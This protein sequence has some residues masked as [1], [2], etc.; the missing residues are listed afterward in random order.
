M[1]NKIFTVMAVLG[2][3]V[4]AGVANAAEVKGMHARIIS[5]SDVV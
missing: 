2:L 5:P 3:M 4:L 1:A